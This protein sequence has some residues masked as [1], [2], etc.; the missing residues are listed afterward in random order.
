MMD[1]VE[2]GL[3]ENVN[4][5]DSDNGGDDGNTSKKHKTKKTTKNTIRDK[6]I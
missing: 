6:P 4:V 1:V 2:S 5:E 3:C